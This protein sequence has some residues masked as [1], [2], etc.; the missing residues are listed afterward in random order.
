[1]RGNKFFCIFVCIMVVWKW[2]VID[3]RCISE[4][5]CVN[6]VSVIKINYR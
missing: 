5:G 6:V 3:L 4:W 2:G 1:M